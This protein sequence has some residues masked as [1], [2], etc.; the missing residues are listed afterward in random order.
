MSRKPSGPNPYL[1]IVGSPRS[2]TTLLRRVVSAHSQIVVAP[3][4]QWIADFY[5]RR[6]GLTQDGTVTDEL[7][8]QLIAHAKFNNLGMTAEDL[9]GLLESGEPPT[10]ASFVSRIFARYGELRGKPLAGD[11]TPNY[12]RQIH[13]LHPL[14]PQARFVHLIR[15]GRDVCLSVRDWQRKAMRMAELFATWSEDP[16]TT[17]A[18]CWERDVRRGRARGGPLGSA[19]YY[20][21]RYE[22]LV[23]DPAGETREL[24][25]FLDLPYEEHMPEFYRAS[26]PAKRQKPKKAWMPIT[27]GLRDWRTQMAP[28][29]VERF[30]AAAGDLLD[31]LGYP[32]A[33][34]SPARGARERAG[35]LRARFEQ[36]LAAR[37]VGA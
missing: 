25:F 17:A 30:E 31:E 8:R 20:E 29:D 28:D 16:V 36:G 15:D 14:W 4:T 35:H 5:N 37:E 13:L 27:P 9:W 18:L 3:E 21:V 7:I 33:Y 10:Y 19:L 22:D 1:F 6:I 34:P 26:P 12:V 32:R 24:C 23:N 2:G 11:K